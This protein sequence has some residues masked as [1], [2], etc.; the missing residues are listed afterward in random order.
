MRILY[1]SAGTGGVDSIGIIKDK[2]KIRT[3]RK[4][5]KEDNHDKSR[6]YFRI[7]RCRKNHF[8]Q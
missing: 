1:L 8:N 4:G 5:R 7:F 6:Y 2:E 3:C